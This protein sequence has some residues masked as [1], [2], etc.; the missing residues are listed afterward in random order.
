MKK[1]VTEIV[2]FTSVSGMGWGMGMGT[3][4]IQTRSA[5][6]NLSQVIVIL[7]NLRTVNVWLILDRSSFKISRK[8]PSLLFMKIINPEHN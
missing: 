7:L 3:T 4:D 1:P 5:L 2:I 8:D 6:R